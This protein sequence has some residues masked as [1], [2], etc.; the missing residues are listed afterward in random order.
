MHYV[1]A[2]GHAIWLSFDPQ[3]GHEQAGRRPALVVSPA[4]Y[5]E[6]VG[7]GPGELFG[8]VAAMYRSPR[9]ATV[10]AEILINRSVASA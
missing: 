4:S 3:R 9:T 1:P 2:R 6:T 10:V 5:N 7:L 8:E